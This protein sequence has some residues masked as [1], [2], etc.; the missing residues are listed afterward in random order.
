[1]PESSARNFRFWTWSLNTFF[2]FNDD[3]DEDD[4][5]KNDDD[6]DDDDEDDNSN[7]ENWNDNHNYRNIRKRWYPVET[8]D[9]NKFVSAGDC[10]SPRCVKWITYAGGARP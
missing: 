10:F 2:Y 9:K 3:D 8:G 5:D 4:D 1:M 6:D 7:N